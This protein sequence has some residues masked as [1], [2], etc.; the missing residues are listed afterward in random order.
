M[1]ESI[2][3]FTRRHKLIQVRPDYVHTDKYQKLAP[4]SSRCGQLH[5]LKIANYIRGISLILE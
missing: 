4:W 5:N 2:A 1:G 3:L